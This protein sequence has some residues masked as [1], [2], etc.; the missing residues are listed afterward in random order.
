MHN[1]V[2]IYDWGWVSVLNL[3]YRQ[4]SQF[5]LRLL[6]ISSRKLMKKHVPKYRLSMNVDTAF[7]SNC[8]DFLKCDIDVIDPSPKYEAALRTYDDHIVYQNVQRY[9]YINI[10]FSYKQGRILYIVGIRYNKIILFVCMFV[11]LFAYNLGT[12]MTITSKFSGQL[13]GAP[14][15]AR[16]QK[17]DIFHIPRHWP[18]THHCGRRRWMGRI[19]SSLY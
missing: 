11:C 16:D 9:K 12:A 5:Q 18:A 4:I 7:F 1:H 17:I 19:A 15:I 14:G 2:D 3:S 10:I 6:K 13:R 8:I